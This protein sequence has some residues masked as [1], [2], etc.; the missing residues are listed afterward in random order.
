MLA[1]IFF[2]YQFIIR[3]SPSV[4]MDEIMVKYHVSASTFGLIIS[5]YYAGYAGMLIPVGALIDKFGVKSGLLFGSL[6]CIIGSLVMLIS[7]DWIN[8]LVGR[9]LIGIG[10][11]AGVLAAIT[12]AKLNFTQREL[13]R[14]LGLTVMIGL[15]GAIY[16]KSINRFLL[17][18]FGFEKTIL[19]LAFP[20]LLIF[21]LVF[22]LS[23]SSETVFIQKKYSVGAALKE[24]FKD[25]KF[26]LV[27]IAG[28]LLVGPLSAFA[29]VFG[30]HYL[31]SVYNISDSKAGYLT[32]SAIYI[33]MAIGAP[34]LTQIASRFKCNYVVNVFCGFGMSLTF[35]LLLNNYI[36]NYSLLFV[37]MIFIGIMSAYQ[38]IVF[39]IISE[40]IS[41]KA[42]GLAI[43][44]ANAIN[45]FAAM[46]YN[47]FVGKLLDCYWTGDTI[48]GMR[49][50]SD[51]AYSD[52]LFIL[53]IALAIG[54]LIFLSVKPKKGIC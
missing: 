49:V 33:G 12:S 45:M 6:F 41:E 19:F 51:V 13:S 31:M 47:F 42:V 50:Y 3:L 37:M 11:C 28:A 23:K 29:D 40:M 14:K 24:I 17:E 54:A 35:Y 53:P 32:T 36:Q 48:Y 44:M 18:K 21:I 27:S 9:T 22:F 4:L 46:L 15:L 26:M 1:V 8:A 2:T 39:S 34:F 43:A 7:D 52:A 20:A 10:S 38:V 25:S 5:F 30:E 16:G